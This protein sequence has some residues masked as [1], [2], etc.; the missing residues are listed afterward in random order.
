MC[1]LPRK[2]P[3]VPHVGRLEPIARL[4]LPLGW[5]E[6]IAVPPTSSRVGPTKVY[7]NLKV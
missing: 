5:E 3:F 2:H 7:H 4:N 6:V 1:M